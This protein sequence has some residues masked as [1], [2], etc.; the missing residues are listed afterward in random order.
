M[1]FLRTFFKVLLTV[2]LV[3]M[4]LGI[5]SVG[6]CAFK[7]LREMAEAPSPFYLALFVLVILIAIAGIHAAIVSIRNVWRGQGVGNNPPTD[8]S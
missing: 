4:T 6:L 1:S 2:F 3:L 5:G 8:E 7:G